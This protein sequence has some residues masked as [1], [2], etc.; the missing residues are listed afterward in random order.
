MEN[1][2]VL[3][4]RKLSAFLNKYYTGMLIKGSILF[5]A[6]GGLYFLLTLA[7]EY[8]LWLSPEIRAILFWLFIGVE[9]I[10]FVKFIFIPL[11]YLLKI[12]K[13]LDEKTASKMIGA[14]FQEI[15]DK[16]L[17]LL[18]LADHPEKSELLLAGIQQRSEELRNIPFQK[19]IQLSSNLKYLKFL[20]IPLLILAIVWLSGKAIS[21][22]DSYTRMVNY[23]TVYNPPAPFSFTVLNDSMTAISG[24]PFQL[25]VATSGKLLPE[26]VMIDRDGT[27]S[28]MQPG[29]NGTF[30]YTLDPAEGPIRFYLKSN[31]VSSGPYTIDVLPV[32]ALLNFSMSLDYPGYTGK[33][34]E[35]LENSGNATV[36]E[37][38]SVSWKVRA[39]HTTKVELMLLDSTL[40]FDT[41]NEYYKI[42]QKVYKTLPYEIATSNADLQRFEKLG[43]RIQVIKDQHPEIQTT[44]M[45]DSL[46]AAGSQRIIGEIS[47][48]YGFKKLELIYYR[49]D[50][51]QEEQKV[52]LSQPA[53]TIDKFAY[54]FP[55]QIQL[56]AGHN[57]RYAFRVTDNDALRNGKTAESTL[58]SFYSMKAQERESLQLEQQKENIKTLDRNI[59]HMER[60]ES[61]LEELKNINK[62]KE[63]LT[64]SDQRKLD[65]FLS[66]QQQQEALMKKYTRKMQE[67]LEQFQQG[68]EQKDEFNELLKERL[69]R[70]QLEIEKNQQLLEEMKKLSEKINKEELSNRLEQL[71]KSQQSNKRSLEQL[72]ELTKRYYVQ[73]KAEN[74]R[75]ALEEQAEIQD[76]LSRINDSQESQSQEELNKQFEETSE[77]LEQLQQENNALKSPM[78]LGRDK[79]QEEQIKK[80]QQEALDQLKAPMKEQT[81]SNKETNKKQENISQKVRKLAQ[82]MTS[83]MSMANAEMINE[84]AAMLRQILD[85]LIKFTFDQEE[86]MENLNNYDQN[87]PNLPVYLRRQ[88]DLKS[89]FE[90]VDDSLFALSLRRPELSEV[91][92]TNITEVYYN[93]DK[94]LERFA[95]NQYYQGI[96]HQQY[97]LTAANNLSDFLSDMLDNMQNM[98]MGS[99]NGS[100]DPFQLPDIIQSQEELNKKMQ[101]GMQK[102]QEGNSKDGEKEGASEQE[103]KGEQDGGKQD[104]TQQGESMSEEIFEIYKQQ[105]QLRQALEN[106][107][108]DMQGEGNKQSAKNL[109]RQMEQIEE[110]L[111]NNGLNAQTLRRMQNLQHQLLKLEDA[112]RM[113]GQKQERESSTN[114]KEFTQNTSNQSNEAQD[115]FQEL[116]ILQR[117][118][119]PLREIYK[120]KVQRYFKG[121]D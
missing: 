13:G 82:N 15:D 59:E 3:I 33:K 32:P 56:E 78:D 103:G 113:Q 106:Q 91:V 68:K 101:E 98:M 6:T 9:M 65:N 79:E 5:L 44:A 50:R 80:E 74:I 11:L 1:Q 95:D 67:N 87:N 36:P 45:E 35:V 31:E 43:F 94:S 64:Y 107:L 39:A 58:Y 17:N 90:H 63:N 4:K 99:G 37:G 8:F 84:D 116:E 86:I 38:T 51:P 23:Q 77:K 16:L 92:N 54:T 7:I 60:Q 119:L 57:Y 105:Q 85:N 81:P 89:L 111:L 73:A 40:E 121:N 61:E 25:R 114:R 2:I 30:E 112:E 66:R 62:Q 28:F 10:L 48:D 49:E 109:S 118:V 34:D 27:E 110:E 55:G 117:Q 120:L 14:H 69:E 70:Q 104:G 97:T 88:N 75:K 83:A 102:Q 76:S 20:A 108:K 22:K 18:Q 47:D 41:E 52:L 96:T 115:S 53:G 26:T 12:R 100:G 71:A 46:S 72:L 24:V 93:M 42:Y 19:A 21:L 29:R